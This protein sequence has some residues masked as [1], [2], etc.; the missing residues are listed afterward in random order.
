MA[1][2]MTSQSPP[3]TILVYCILLIIGSWLFV[4]G[5]TSLCRNICISTLN[6]L[7]S[8]VAA[9]HSQLAEV[10]IGPNVV[11]IEG[12]PFFAVSTESPLGAVR[13]GGFCIPPHQAMQYRCVSFTAPHLNTVLRALLTAAGFTNHQSLLDSIT[14]VVTSL[15][16]ADL[17][18]LRVTPKM[19]Q[20]VVNLATKH[21]DMLMNTG[22]LTSLYTDN[23]DY[24]RVYS[25]TYLQKRTEE[26]PASSEVSNNILCCVGS[27]NVQ[28]VQISALFV[29]LP[30]LFHTGNCYRICQIMTKVL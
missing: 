24:L 1:T 5:I 19:L 3:P 23:A 2:V 9:V 6:V 28:I 22:S 7:H 14:T 20:E 4:Q 27:S 26:V 13:E 15:P 10:K 17:V 11:S 18:Y 25:E 21:Q 30:L 12:S 16:L 8:V 29:N